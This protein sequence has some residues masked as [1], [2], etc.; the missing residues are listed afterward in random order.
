MARYT[1]EMEELTDTP[2]YILVS[3]MEAKHGYFIMKSIETMTNGNFIVGPASMYTTIQKL[4]S[5]ELIELVDEGDRRKKTYIT[6]KKGVQLL[7]K[8]VKR[9][10]EMVR[11]AEKMFKEKGEPLA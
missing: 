1:T 4:L 8:E 9:R 7:K 5:A 3:L 6:T 10:Q 2:F 11:H